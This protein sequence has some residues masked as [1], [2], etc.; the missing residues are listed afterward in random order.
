MMLEKFY[1]PV[2]GKSGQHYIPRNFFSQPLQSLLHRHFPK[3]ISWSESGQGEGRLWSRRDQ[4]VVVPGT[5]GS[6]EQGRAP[7]PGWALPWL[8]GLPLPQVSAAFS[9][10]GLR[11]DLRG[12]C[13]S[14]PPNFT[15]NEWFSP[16]Y[17]G[18]TSSF[19]CA[20]PLPWSGGIF[21]FPLED[22]EENKG[23]DF[24]GWC[25]RRN[26]SPRNKC[27]VPC[28]CS[29]PLVLQ[30]NWVF[31][32]NSNSLVYGIKINPLTLQ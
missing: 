16:L 31:R 6:W 20:F 24:H 18:D 12:L 4:A 26:P 3:S 7:V 14:H 25:V 13:W 8:P 21:L 9:T 22:H 5:D 27:R 30:E 17:P 28:A 2:W 29:A 11:R 32:G 23:L 15:M 19:P 10:K 1:V